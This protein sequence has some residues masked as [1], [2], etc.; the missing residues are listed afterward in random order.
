MMKH[1]E[2]MKSIANTVKDYLPSTYQNYN[3]G[4]TKW[5]S[6]IF[7]DSDR[8]IH[9]EISRTRN[10]HGRCLE[11]AFHMESRSKAHNRALLEGFDAHLLQ[12]REELGSDVKAEQWDRGW[13][14][15]YEILPDEELTED[16]LQSVAERWA[17]FICVVQ[18]IYEHIKE[19]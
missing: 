17:S 12:M 8:R 18:P 16:W 6:Q 4:K 5:I 2:F 19:N 14:K 11:I 13:T 15:V 1:T 3:K 10:Q 9:Y 7:L